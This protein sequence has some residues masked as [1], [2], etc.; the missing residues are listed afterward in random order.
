MPYYYFSCNWYVTPNNQIKD[1][2]FQKTVR[3]HFIRLLL[4]L[5]FPITNANQIFR[6]HLLTG[7]FHWFRLNFLH[8]SIQ[9]SPHGRFSTETSYNLHSMSIWLL[10][11]NEQVTLHELIH[12]NKF[13]AISSINIRL[14]ASYLKWVYILQNMTSTSTL[15][16]YFTPSLCPDIKG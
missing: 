3:F 13:T 5:E 8:T 15:N 6:T 16:Q 1:K 2:M 12:I 10:Q 9:F 14:L 4:S 11:Y 7:I